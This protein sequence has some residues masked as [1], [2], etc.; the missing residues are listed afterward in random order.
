MGKRMTFDQA[1]VASQ[2]YEVTKL[3]IRS[4]N[5]ALPLAEKR[6]VPIRASDSSTELGETVRRMPTYEK[7]RE[8]AYRLAISPL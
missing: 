3:Y 5:S 6:I 1:K 7:E 2:L 4:P 8:G